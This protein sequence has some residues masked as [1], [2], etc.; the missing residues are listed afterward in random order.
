MTGYA[1]A[2]IENFPLILIHFVAY[3]LDSHKINTNAMRKRKY[4]VWHVSPLDQSLKEELDRFRSWMRSERKSPLTVKQYSFL[5]SLFFDF[6]TKKPED[7]REDDIEKFKIYLISRRGYSKSSQYLVMEAIRLFFKYK[8]LRAPNNLTSPKR[9]KKLPIYL[10]ERETETLLNFKTDPLKSAMINVLVYSGIRVSELCSLD[11]DDIDLEEGVLHVRGGKG[12]KD[13]IVL[14]AEP[15]IASLRTYLSIRNREKSA[16]RALF[17]SHKK[18]RFSPVSVERI[19]KNQAKLA[20]I[21]KKV[22]PHVL[23]HTFATSV[24]RNGGDI[25]F[26][27]QLLGHSS[28][29]TT[30]IYTHIDE[31]ALREMY[32]KHVPRYR[33]GNQ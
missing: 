10:N 15:C 33:S 13:R 9:S 27:Q 16:S 26:I 18:G 28:I 17:I 8:G 14:I 31:D 24:L 30:E 1:V 29:A 21:N 25:R 5:L 2:S 23:R 4:G 19:I 12:D 3:D 20:G 7:I 11:L 6:I 22:T 32:N